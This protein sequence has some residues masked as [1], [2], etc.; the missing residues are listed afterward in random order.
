MEG[1]IS[2]P[3]IKYACM[4]TG[5]TSFLRKDSYSEKESTTPRLKRPDKETGLSI[6]VHK[7]AKTSSRD[8]HD[9]FNDVRLLLNMS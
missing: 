3:L 8:I 5:N 1:C 2:F 4:E 9:F 6:P 7:C